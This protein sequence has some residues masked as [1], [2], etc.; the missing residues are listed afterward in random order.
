MALTKFDIISQAMTL[1]DADEV[2]TWGTS[3]P[4]R[5]EE[6]SQQLILLKKLKL[7]GAERQTDFLDTLQLPPQMMA[8]AIM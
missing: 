3:N 7:G 2:D 6:V 4:S 5:E 8:T 1:L